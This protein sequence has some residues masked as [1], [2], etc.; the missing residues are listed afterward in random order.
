[1]IDPS[2]ELRV[3]LNLEPLD[4]DLFRASASKGD[5][6][7]RI[8][9]GQVIAQGLAAA[10]ETVSDKLCHSLHAYFVRPGDPG[11]PV[12]FQVD[13]ARDGRSFATRRVIAIQGGRQ[14]LN[15]SASFHIQEAGWHHQHPIPNVDSPEISLKK[16]PKTVASVDR[17]ALD[18]DYFLRHIDKREIDPL[19]PE[20]P[21]FADD[22][23][24]FWFRMPSAVGV[25]FK[26]QQ[27]LLAY[28]SDTALLG[29]GLRPHGISWTQNKVQGASLDHA[30]WFHAPAR[31]E[32]WNLYSLDSPWTGNARCFGRG[33]IFSRDGVLVASVAQEGLIRPIGSAVR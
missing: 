6:P 3:I 27:L 31:L 33:K 14:L 21:K 24:R 32:D 10:Y 5:L 26:M 29:T 16:K 28:A 19:D 4:R 2:Q 18:S 15:L 23:N 17:K 22:V 7:T 30:L 20:D 11:Q 25:D 13:R 1:V 8:F 9:G 12:N